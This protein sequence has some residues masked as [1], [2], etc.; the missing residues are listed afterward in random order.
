[1][2]N[3]CAV[4]EKFKGFVVLSENLTGKRVMR[5][6]SDNGVEYMSEGFR[7]YCRD[8]GISKE[9]MRDSRNPAKTSIP[10]KPQ[11]NG[12]AKRTNCT[13][14]ETVRSILHHAGLPLPFWA[15]AVSTA[16]Y[17]RNRCPTSC[18]KENTPYE[19][20]HNEKPDVS[21]FKVL[22]CNALVHIPDEKRTKLGKKSMKCIFVVG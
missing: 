15:E 11:Q 3:K 12:I 21:N 6:R 20:W 10:Y 16:V 5:L 7:K 9:I 1:M 18:L 13:I 14:M 22:D 17:I 4:L 8:H 19:C 2:K